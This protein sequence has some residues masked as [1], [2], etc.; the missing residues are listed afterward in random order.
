MLQKKFKF[1]NFSVNDY[2][3]LWKLI[4]YTEYL[5]FTVNCK[6]RSSHQTGIQTRFIKCVSTLAVKKFHLK[7]FSPVIFVRLTYFLVEHTSATIKNIANALSCVDYRYNENLVETY[8]Q[9]SFKQV[10]SVTN[11]AFWKSIPVSFINFNATCGWNFIDLF[12][13][14]M[15]VGISS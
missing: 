13:M 15:S 9:S 6:H 1:K 7:L 3:I 10:F 14:I 2:V 4:Q 8:N 5:I 11:F 12:I